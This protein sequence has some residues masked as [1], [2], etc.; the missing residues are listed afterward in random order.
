MCRLW[1]GEDFFP[2]AIPAIARRWS[3]RF[4]GPKGFT[5]YFEGAEEER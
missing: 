5:F 2:P 4:S 3:R 1:V